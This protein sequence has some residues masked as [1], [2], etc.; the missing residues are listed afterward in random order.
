MEGKASDSRIVVWIKISRI[1]QV[2]EGG[3]GGGMAR[4]TS[5][6]LGWLIRDSGRLITMGRGKFKVM[7]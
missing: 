4:M 1:L 3:E 2:N 6:S 5:S 7:F